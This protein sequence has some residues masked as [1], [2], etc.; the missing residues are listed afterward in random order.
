MLSETFWDSN[1]KY[2]IHVQERTY[3]LMHTKEGISFWNYFCRIQSK[4]QLGS[5]R[6]DFIGNLVTETI[7]KRN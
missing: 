2:L 3:T 6:K 1:F 5:A 4:F 7:F